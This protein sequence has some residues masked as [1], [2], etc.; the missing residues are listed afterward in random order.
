[1]AYQL[2]Q[3]GHV[4]QGKVVEISLDYAASVKVMDNANYFSFKK[5]GKYKYLG[6]YVKTSPYQVVIP[7]SAKWYVVF[8]LD[9]SADKVASSVKVLP[10]SAFK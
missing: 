1:M 5:G 8:E 6:A 3:L 7:Y 10:N 9:G 4:E 2:S